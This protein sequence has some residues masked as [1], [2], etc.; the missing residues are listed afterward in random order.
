MPSATFRILDSL[1]LQ[2]T[3]I[4]HI[5]LTAEDLHPADEGLG[6]QISLDPAREHRL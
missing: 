3:R 4:R 1:A 2:R 5:T 6:T